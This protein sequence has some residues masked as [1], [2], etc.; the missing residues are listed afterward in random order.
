MKKIATVHVYVNKNSSMLL[1]YLEY[2]LLPV[3]FKDNYI[4]AHVG[5]LL[6]FI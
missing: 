4:T 5:L 2:F 6:K 3:D 1:V